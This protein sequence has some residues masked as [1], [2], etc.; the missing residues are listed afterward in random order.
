MLRWPHHS[1]CERGIT[2]S[3]FAQGTLWPN[4]VC[5]VKEE[6]VDKAYQDAL[7]KGHLR[8]TG[9]DSW[10]NLPADRNSMKHLFIKGWKV[11]LAK[12]ELPKM[13]KDFTQPNIHYQKDAYPSSTSTPPAAPVAPV[14]QP[15]EHPRIQQMLERMEY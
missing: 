6:I 3:Q 1:P 7:D 9:Y 11:V 5:A 13:G 10:Y 15:S 2:E 14:S 8:I 4:Y 12:A